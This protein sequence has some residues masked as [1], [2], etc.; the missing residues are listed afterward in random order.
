MDNQNSSQIKNLVLDFM[1]LIG[2]NPVEI[3]PEIWKAHIPETEKYFFNGFE[4]INFTFNRNIAE[5]HR[6]LE[7][8]AEGTYLLKKILERL[9]SIPKVS[10]IYKCTE[11]Q[12]ITT[13]YSTLPNHIA[14]VT[15]FYK[16]DIIFNFKVL[17]SAES[18]FEKLYTVYASPYTSEIKILEEFVEIRLDKNYSEHP[19]YNILTEDISEEIIRF[20][21]MSCQLLEQKITP[22]IL[23]LQN[24]S[25]K[26]LNSELERYKAYINEQKEELQRKK[27][28]VS[29]HLYFF[30]KEEEIDKLLQNI[31]LELEQK[32]QELKSKY[33]VSTTINLINAIILHIPVIGVPKYKISSTSQNLKKCN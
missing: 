30:Q 32:I 23:E 4:E 20:Y 14:P 9:I 6:N 13:I 24:S 7:Y 1:H 10:K 2:I 15:T 28:N 19:P 16:Q 3:E 33:Q 8:I 5:T 11:P 17:F 25:Q 31:D 27:Q 18:K 22:S 26:A 29:F 21:L 12:P